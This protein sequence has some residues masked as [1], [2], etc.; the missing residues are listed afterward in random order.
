MEKL[1]ETINAIKVSKTT[2]NGL[3]KIAQ[4]E[5][6]QIQQVCRKLLSKKAFSYFSIIAK[7]Y[8]IVYNN[9]NYKR[10]NETVLISQMPENWDS[11]DFSDDTDLEI[12]ISELILDFWNKNLTVIFT[13]KKDMQIALSIIQ[14]FHKLDNMENFNK[15][16]IYSVIKQSTNCKT[17]D[18]TKVVKEMKIHH[19]KLIK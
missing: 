7:N 19:K 16:D 11:D 13:D 3:V 15:K 18:I 14:L 8:L 12:N 1:T 4:M 9:L 2:K 10:F 17:K 5:E 6:I